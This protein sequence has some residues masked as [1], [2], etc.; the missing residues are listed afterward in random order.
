MIPI[1]RLPIIS[2]K[3]KFATKPKDADLYLLSPVID[4]MIKKLPAVTSKPKPIL[5]SG[6]SF[7]PSLVAN[8][9]KTK[10][11]SGIIS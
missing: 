7:N 3:Q 5:R 2:R 11:N 1:P 10:L 9:Y 8:G 6:V 4:A